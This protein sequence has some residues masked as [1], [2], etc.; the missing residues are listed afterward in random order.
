MDDRL[1]REKAVA[2]TSLTSF[3]GG[4]EEKAW[5]VLTSLSADWSSP[6]ASYT[7]EFTENAEEE[8]AFNSLWRDVRSSFDS[9][10]IPFSIM[11]YS[12]PDSTVRFLYMAG[13]TSLLE[14]KKLCFLGA[15]MPSLQGRKDTAEAVMEAVKNGWT[16][17]A[18][19]DSGLGP[20][21][22]SVALKEGGKALAVLSSEL[23]KCPNENLLPLMENIYSRGL[24]VSQFSPYTKREKW[25]VVLRNRFLSSFADAYYMAEEKDG[26]PGWAVFDAALKSGRKCALSSSSAENPN[27]SWCARRAETGAAVIRKPRELKALFPS[28]RRRKA[29]AEDPSQGDLFSLPDNPDKA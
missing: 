14:G 10:R 22:L 15:V 27:Y 16:V 3:Y 24:L 25:H 2:Y 18:P 21:A 5:S 17:V 8:A 11:D 4:D 23:T 19:F 9:C 7:R 29:R 1:I 20:Y 12:S 28:C 6:F 26:G 13:D